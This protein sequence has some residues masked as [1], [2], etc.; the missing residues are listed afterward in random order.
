MPVG[1]GASPAAP[2]AFK[3]A[4]NFSHQRGRVWLN[5]NTRPRRVLPA[6]HKP[7]TDDL[8]PAES[9]EFYAPAQAARA[10]PSVAALLI[11]LRVRPLT[12]DAKGS[13]FGLDKTDDQRRARR[14]ERAGTAH[15][16]PRSTAP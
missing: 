12:R 7:T 6:R 1:A 10:L 13:P 16:G 11:I 2:T 5:R 8:A 15:G 9:P 4:L 14:D 3:R